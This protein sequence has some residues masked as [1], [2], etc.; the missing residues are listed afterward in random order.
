[1]AKYVIHHIER[2]VGLFEVEAES[3]DDAILEFNRKVDNGEIDFSDMELTFC[4]NIARRQTD[5][6]K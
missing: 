2:L 1:M 3:E 6:T 5:D 4:Q